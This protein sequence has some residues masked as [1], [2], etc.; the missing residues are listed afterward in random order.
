MCRRKMHAYTPAS[1]SGAVGLQRATELRIAFC[2]GMVVGIREA[3]NDEH[4]SQ[5]RHQE[6]VRVISSQF[7]TR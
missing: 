5:Q 1:V 3:L 6:K 7:M 4:Q 2:N